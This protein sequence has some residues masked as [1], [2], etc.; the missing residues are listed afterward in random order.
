M[1][2]VD[3]ESPPLSTHEH[4]HLVEVRGVRSQV[5]HGKRP[6]LR[7][8]SRHDR[9]G[10]LTRVEGLLPA[11]AELAEDPAYDA[12]RDPKSTFQLVQNTRAG[13][14]MWGPGYHPSLKTR[15]GM[16]D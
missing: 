5:F 14:L 2:A 12:Q 4:T 6:A 13:M 7:R 11:G 8:H 1:A 9:R 10:G 3:D 15:D 16:V